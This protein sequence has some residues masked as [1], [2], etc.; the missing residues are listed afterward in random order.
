MEWRTSLDV[1]YCTVIGIILLVLLAISS[2]RLHIKRG[3]LVGNVGACK[4]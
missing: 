2:A 3:K 4:K 1:S